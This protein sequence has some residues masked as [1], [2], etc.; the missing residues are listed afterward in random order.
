MSHQN[1]RRALYEMCRPAYDKDRKSNEQA[2]DEMV[3]LLTDREYSR[4]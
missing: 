1:E 4:K 2:D 3:V